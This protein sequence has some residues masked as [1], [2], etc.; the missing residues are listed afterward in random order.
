MKRFLFAIAAYLLLLPG[1]SA[2]QKA[3]RFEWDADYSYFFDNREFA[4]SSDEYAYSETVNAAVLTPSV[5]INVKN[6]KNVNHRLRLG[7]DLYKNMGGAE[8]NA[9]AIRELTLFYD[10]HVS[11]E[12]ARFEGLAGCFPR[13]YMEGEYGEAFFDDKYLFTDRNLEGVLMKYRARNFFAE[14]GCDWMGSKGE[15]R[16]ERFQVFS[17]GNWKAS[18]W[19]SLGWAGSFYH[20]A[21]SV[22]AP[23]VVDNH[24]FNPYLKLDFSDFVALKELSLKAGALVSYQ[25]NRRVDE[26]AYDPYGGQFDLTLKQWSFGI[27][28]SLYLGYDQQVYFYDRDVSGAMYGTDLYFGSPF[29]QLKRYSRT[30]LFWQ[31]QLTDYLDLKLSCLLH[32]GSAPDGAWLGSRQVLSLVFDLERLRRPSCVSGRTG[33]PSV[34]RPRSLRDFLNL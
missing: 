1:V 10:A 8:I 25:R 12:N 31:P 4:P 5:G 32:F 29:Y 28:S 30:E 20:Y 6:T 13:S 3:V 24:L 27:V 7:L 2:Q 11:M 22:V 17:A 16:H 19:L 26:I 18:S 34:P 33:Q 9:G 21:S 23:G 15:T 14:L